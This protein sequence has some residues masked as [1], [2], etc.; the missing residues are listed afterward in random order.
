MSKI[1]LYPGT[2]DP[3]TNGHLS[4]IKKGLQV[5]D[6]IIVGVARDTPKA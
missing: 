5:F 3:I 2:F 1:A 6:E 4:L